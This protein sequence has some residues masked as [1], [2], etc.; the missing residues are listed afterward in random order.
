[1]QNQPKPRDPEWTIIKLLKWTTSYFKSHDIDSPRS[2]AEILLAHVLKLKR[3]DLYL[4]YDK[5][6][7]IDELSKFKVLI[8]RRIERE[9]VA[10]ITGVK[11]F[12]SMDFAVTKDVLIPR[13]ETEC[14]VEAALSLLPDD[15]SPD[16]KRMPKSILELGTGSGA[17]ILAIASM[18]PKYIYF[19]SDHSVKAVKLARQNSK[20]HGLDTAVNFFCADWLMPL[21][22]E[23]QPFDMIISN[24]PYVPT[25]V[26]GRLQPEI[27][28]YEPISALDG[29]KDGLF[30]LRHII[31]TAHLYLNPNGSLL[32]EIGH[33]QK[34][35]V[36][37]IIEKCG[38]YENVVFINDYSGYNR[39]VRVKKKK[40]VANQ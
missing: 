37:S 19:A 22:S 27:Y 30:C 29:G 25:M 26:I 40:T 2:T 23:M 32:L 21:K 33:D 24:P 6:L 18:W 20:L 4:Q 39:V 17:V 28:K 14:L 15:K 11:E 38:N 34:N 10:Y 16:V 8:K 12:W 1:M 7:Y 36:R 5:P 9:P 13:P 35:D 3:I 31:N